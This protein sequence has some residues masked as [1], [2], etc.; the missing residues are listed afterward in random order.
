MAATSSFEKLALLILPEN[1][2]DEFFVKF[3]F[4]DVPCLKTAISKGLGA[5]IILGS[6]IVK[7]PQIMKI[8]SAKS[9]KG[10]SMV[11]IIFEMA[12]IS[13]TWSYSVGNGFPFSA[14]G[15]AFFLAVQTTLIGALCLQFNGKTALAGVF[16]VTYCCIMF[17]LL[18]GAVPLEALAVLQS[19][20]ILLVI[21]SRM[22]QAY[23]NYSS[24]H[25]G[26]LSLITFTLLFLGAVARIFTSIQE[27]GG[28]PLIVA[29][30][31]ASTT[32]NGII[33]SQILYY[34]SAKTKT[35]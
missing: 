18:S 32:C 22:T 11:S 20:N 29:T 13:A 15:E 19:M 14:W 3:N 6:V 21:I 27:T 35:E 30:Y 7:L 10:I 31:C 23:S 2:Y 16:I 1:C 8:L 9:G 24:G 12:A 28:D 33:V 34:S 5:I 25:T 17:V 4:L 26:Q